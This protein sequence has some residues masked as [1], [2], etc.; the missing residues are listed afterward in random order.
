MASNDSLAIFRRFSDM[1]MLNLLCLQSD[2]STLRAEF[3]ALTSPA[4]N[5]PLTNKDFFQNKNTID[6]RKFLENNFTPQR[7]VFERLRVKLTEYSE[8]ATLHGI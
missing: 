2:I 7:D 6:F 5:G 3:L 4:K 8:S 1:N